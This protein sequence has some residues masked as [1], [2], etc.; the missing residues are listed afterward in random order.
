MSLAAGACGAARPA[1]RFINYGDGGRTIELMESPPVIRTLPRAERE[2]AIQ[3]A[4][5]ERGAAPA[6]PTIETTSGTLQEALA[7]ARARPSP[8][9]H[10]RAGN[11]Y[12]HVG[13]L[14]FAID[15][16]DR[17]IAMDS[18][19][20]A[21]YDGRARVWRDWGLLGY[22]LSDATRAVYFAPKSAT[23]H[24][25]RGTILTLL[26]R[27]DSARAAYERALQLDPGAGYAKHNL[28]RQG[29]TGCRPPVPSKASTPPH[30]A[31]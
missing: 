31:R 12:A 20:A 11:A 10:V 2:A 24:N 29:A 23:A 5:L 22:A 16:F 30:P 14:D 15:Q 6:V 4:R 28:E 19:S 26:G 13:V 1:N 25:T 17:A 27:C 8:A 7:E 9:A 21:A 3:K 18:R